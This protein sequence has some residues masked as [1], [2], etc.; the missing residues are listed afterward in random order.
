ME[1]CVYIV[2]YWFVI[3]AGVP[4]VST[5]PDGETSH[6]LLIIHIIVD[7]VADSALIV[8]RYFRTETRLNHQ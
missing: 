7:R 5:I 3:A 2:M 4:N 6:S 8:R 1:S